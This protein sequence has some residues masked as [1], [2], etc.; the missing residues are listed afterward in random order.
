[1]KATEESVGDRVEI[2][3]AA[4]NVD[5]VEISTHESNKNI[6]SC[7]EVKISFII[8]LFFSMITIL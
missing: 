3:T 7:G 2:D 5:E 1:M 4:N 8:I 6:F